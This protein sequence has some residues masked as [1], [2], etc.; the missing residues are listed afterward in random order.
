[1]SMKLAIKEFYKPI[2]IFVIEEI[3]PFG[4]SWYVFNEENHNF[5]SPDYFSQTYRWK[6]YRHNYSE[7]KYA[8]YAIETKRCLFQRKVRY[9]DFV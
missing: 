2:Q 4:K 3:S 1:M 5:L 8:L 6:P 7:L 9:V